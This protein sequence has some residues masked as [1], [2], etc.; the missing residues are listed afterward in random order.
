MKMFTCSVW[1]PVDSNYCVSSHNTGHGPDSKGTPH[2]KRVSPWRVAVVPTQCFVAAL[3]DRLGTHGHILAF[4]YWTQLTIYNVWVYHSL[5]RRKNK[6]RLNCTKRG[7]FQ[8][9]HLEMEEGRK[10]DT[11]A[12]VPSR[13]Q[14]MAWCGHVVCA[15]QLFAEAK[16]LVVPSERQQLK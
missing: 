2:S 11:T 5:Q 13:A 6:A 3:L 10:G 15:Q 16:A 9:P 14:R 8:E 7:G 1:R 4:S 12:Q